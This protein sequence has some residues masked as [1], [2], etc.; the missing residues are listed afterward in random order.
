ML[1]QQKGLGTSRKLNEALIRE[2]QQEE[3]ERMKRERET[4]GLSRSR[5][6]YVN[7]QLS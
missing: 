2:K 7:S 5:R 6:N 3:I 4:E 1:S